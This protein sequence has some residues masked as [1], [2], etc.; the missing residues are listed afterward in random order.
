MIIDLV[1]PGDVLGQLG[2]V[3]QVAQIVGTLGGAEVVAIVIAFRG[4]IV[5]GGVQ[6]VERGGEIRIQERACVGLVS[7][8]GLARAAGEVPGGAVLV[9]LG[10][11][12]V[13]QVEGQ[14]TA[15][16]VVDVF[17]VDL[18]A[19]LLAVEVPGAGLLAGV[20]DIEAVVSGERAGVEAHEG[21]AGVVA[22]E[23]LAQLAAELGA[24]V[25]AEGLY[26]AAQ[27][28]GR[29]GAQRAGPRR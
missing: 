25:V 2:V 9:R 28:A 18:I 15:L 17:Q 12:R 16:A 26:R 22:A 21:A 20:G 13:R 23:R 6:I 19:A 7:V 4:R 10:L 5:A 8:G 3:L 29:G 11:V 14:L 24:R 1:R 27:V